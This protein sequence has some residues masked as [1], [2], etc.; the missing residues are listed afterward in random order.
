VKEIYISHPKH[1]PFE[2][3][4]ITKNIDVTKKTSDEV[5][6][7][8]LTK[9]LDVSVPIPLEIEKIQLE[10]ISPVFI[11]TTIINPTS[12]DFTSPFEYLTYIN[13][14]LYST[15]KNDCELNYN[16]PVKYPNS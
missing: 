8:D 11:K 3:N 13:N 4:Q 6:N 16:L 10:T 15:C 9:E 7:D 1:V 2:Y 5:L 12:E 14:K